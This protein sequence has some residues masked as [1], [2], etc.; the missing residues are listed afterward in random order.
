MTTAWVLLL[1][2][3]Y[4]LGVFK[5]NQWE[6]LGMAVFIVVFGLGMRYLKKNTRVF[7]ID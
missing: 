1:F 6:L 7:K 2:Q 3:T 5:A 4:I